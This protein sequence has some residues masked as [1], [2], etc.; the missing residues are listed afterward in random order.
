[1]AAS[2]ELWL[3]ELESFSELPIYFNLF[4]KNKRCKELLFKILGGEPDLATEATEKKKWEEEQ[5]EA[6]QFNYKILSETFAFSD[7]TKLRDT[8]IDCGF[9]PRILERLAAVSGEKPR[10]YEE[11]PEEVVEEKDEPALIK[12]KSEEVDNKTKKKRAGVGYSA[13]QGETF[14]VT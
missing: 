13:K 5:K 3:K 1:M 8:A 11:D 7:D 9:L 2:W 4:L 10:V 12:A 14:N 6:V